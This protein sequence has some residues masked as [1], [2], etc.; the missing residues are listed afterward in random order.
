VRFVP[1][2]NRIAVRS[3]QLPPEVGTDPA[4]RMILATSLILGMSL[5]TKDRRMRAYGKVRTIW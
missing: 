5:V 2:D 1:I 3:T 4:D